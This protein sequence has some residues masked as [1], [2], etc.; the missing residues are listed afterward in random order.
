MGAFLSAIGGA[1][2]AAGHYGEQIRG[3]LEG[4]RGELAH[5]IGKAAEDEADPNTLTALRG[6]QADLLSGKPMGAIA[7]KFFTT[8]QKRH[9]DAQ[10]MH[11]ATQNF[12][13]MIGQA[14]TPPPVQPGPAA[15]GQTPGTVGGP[16]ATSPANPFT[17]GGITNGVAPSPMA[18]MVASTPQVQSAPPAAQPATNPLQPGA[19]AIPPVA[20]G[21]P[22]LRD[23]SAIIQEMMANPAYAAPVNRRALEGQAQT[24]ITHN[25][26]VRQFREQ[27]QF[28]RAQLEEFKKTPTWA[29]LP[30]I[31]KAQY[32]A[33]ASGL[34][35][36]PMSAQMM[37]PH[38]ISTGTL[39]AQAPS[40]TMELG[41]GNPVNPKGLYRVLFNPLSQETQWQ[42]I[43]SQTTIT[44]TPT[45]GQ[46]VTDRKTGE[47]IAPV[48]GAVSPPMATPRSF[49]GPAGNVFLQSPASI[50][51][52]GQ[53]IPVPGAVNPAF[54]PSIT[55]ST[56][57]IPGQ[58][59]EHRTAV[60]TKGTNPA[61]GGG[62]IQPVSSTAKPSTGGADDI[63]KQA[64]DSWVSGGPAPTGKTLNS[65]RDYQAKNKL[66][67]PITMSATGQQNVQAVDA[68]F[69]EIDDA[70]KTLDQIKGNP[71]LA[72]DYM[73]YKHLGQ[74]TPYD[75]LFTKLSFEGLRS[76][77]AALK[78]NN[79][80][81]YP[82]IQKAFEH[83][84][85]LDRWHGLNP[86][87]ISLMKDKLKAM[88]DVL[89]DTRT[90]VLADERK[91]GVIQPLT[92]AAPAGGSN[93][94]LGIR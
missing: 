48:A 73:K 64:Y 58:P 46:Q 34:N 81:A 20:T 47:S 91:S 53:S 77:A 63:T 32:E 71:S 12:G 79:S 86:D 23:N 82:I 68:V 24:E 9:Q 14:A 37:L 3:I 25:E 56:T 41:T 6:H 11:E 50:A 13:Q 38:M 70:M 66:P 45:G 76:A 43:A 51:S 88:R 65:V 1:G 16:G 55:S 83:V 52:G 22:A 26:N 27:I 30:D 94:P 92:G 31:T 35:A 18:D 42:P 75:S 87:A 33:E 80:R 69:K 5:L 36:A 10:A 54:I 29:N 15:P 40:G 21:F 39:G 85:N 4:R 7:Q 61:G 19:P 17:V 62:S 8:L 84:P 67:D 2:N 49:T 93:D 60:R 44:T 89:N 78:G 72:V 28:K 74:S 57:Q 90:T 59:T